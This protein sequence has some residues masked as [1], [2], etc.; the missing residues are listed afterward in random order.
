MRQRTEDYLKALTGAMALAALTGLILNLCGCD[1]QEQARYM[2][3]CIAECD[4]KIKHDLYKE[5][6]QSCSKI[7]Y[8]K[9]DKESK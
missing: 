5:C 9:A 3:L 4:D 7:A 1:R 8:I 6:V 2:Y